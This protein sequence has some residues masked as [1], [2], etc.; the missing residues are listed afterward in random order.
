MSSF[1]VRVRSSQNVDSTQASAALLY[2]NRRM[3][4][5]F[6]GHRFWLI[7]RNIVLLGGILVLG[8][9]LRFNNVT[10]PFTDAFS[11]RQA[12]TAMMASNFYHRSWNIFYPEVS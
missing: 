10:Q 3:T 12:S 8:A 2:S 1:F 4:F 9:V 11:W 6:E 7:P 5:S